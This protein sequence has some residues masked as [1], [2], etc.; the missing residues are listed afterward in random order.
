M[1]SIIND[2]NGYQLEYRHLIQN[3]TTKS[4][5]DNSFFNEL[6]ILSQGYDD[7]IK[8]TNTMFSSPITKLQ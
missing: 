7:T 1:N 5:W 4:L 3:P 8:G 2:K 6:G